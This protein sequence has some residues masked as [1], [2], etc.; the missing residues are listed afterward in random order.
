M[1][2]KTIQHLVLSFGLIT[3][4]VQLVECIAEPVKP[5]VPSEVVPDLRR[6]KP[7]VVCIDCSEPFDTAT[8]KKVLKGLVDNSYIGELRKAL[9]LQDS[10]HQFESKAHFDNCDFDG[11]IAYIDMLIDQVNGH[12]NGAQKAK[13]AGDSAKTQ[14]AAHNAFFAIGQ[15]LHAVQ[16]FYAH[17]NY[18][19]LTEQSV[20]RIT[21]LDV[22]A[23]WQS[24]GKA[25]INQLRQDGRK[26]LVSGFVFWG[27]PQLCPLGSMSHA[28][29]A[30]DNATTTSGKV[31]VANLEN[32]SQYDIAVYLAREASIKFLREAFKWWPLLKEL[33]GP[34]LAFDV[35]LDRR[36]I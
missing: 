28:D 3:H 32:L 22:I 2:R 17:S 8:H 15:V 35:L 23:P 30:K 33:N 27:F 24:E 29:L 19:E 31:K 26:G 1:T 20:N 11:A 36:E 21:D 13:K 7:T 18:V 4:L 12:V 9:Y 16:D 25:R 34:N 10:L 5:P 14:A 6:V